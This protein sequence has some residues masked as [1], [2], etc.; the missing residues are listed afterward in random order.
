MKGIEMQ[1]WGYSKEHG[2]VVL[3]RRVP[4]NAPGIKTDLLFVRCQ[5]ATIVGVKRESWN[6]PSYKFAPNYLRELAPPASDE[7]AAELEG[8]KVRWPEFEREIQRECRE[9]EGRAQAV[10]DE[11]EKARKQAASERRKQAAAA[12][13]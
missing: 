8:F 4:A 5:D 12:K 13:V 6:P 2:W 3:D 10:R 9:T 7:A 1:W 11:E